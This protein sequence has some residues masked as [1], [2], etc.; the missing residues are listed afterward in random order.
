MKACDSKNVSLYESLS[1]YNY[2]IVSRESSVLLI[3][4]ICDGPESYRIVK[5]TLD[6]W[7]YPSFEKVGNLQNK[8][9]SHR[10]ISNGDRIYVVG[11]SGSQKFVKTFFVTNDIFRANF[12]SLNASSKNHHSE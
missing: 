3:G 8:R 5:S 1:F 4:G 9:H 11:G 10:A 12:V 6:R 7:D 2:G